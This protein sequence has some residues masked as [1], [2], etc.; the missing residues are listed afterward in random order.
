MS[1]RATVCFVYAVCVSFHVLSSSLVCVYVSI[2]AVFPCSPSFRS[3]STLFFT[4]FFL[5]FSY[6]GLL[7]CCLTFV[8][9]RK[10]HTHVDWFQL[11]HLCLC[12]RPWDVVLRA[13]HRGHNCGQRPPLGGAVRPFERLVGLVEIETAVQHRKRHTVH[14]HPLHWSHNA[15]QHLLACHS[16]CFSSLVDSCHSTFSG[17]IAPLFCF[18]SLTFRSVSFSQRL[19]VHK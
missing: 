7:V 2:H 12:R 17:V 8:C 19:N 16:V 18:T 10:E 9:T 13:Y 15:C 11:G 5:I 14:A 1:E 4:D 3:K 6:T